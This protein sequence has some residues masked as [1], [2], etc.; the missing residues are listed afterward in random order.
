[1]SGFIFLAYY[2]FITGIINFEQMRNTMIMAINI[3]M[4][5]Y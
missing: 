2:D 3:L 5:M 4:T 1:M